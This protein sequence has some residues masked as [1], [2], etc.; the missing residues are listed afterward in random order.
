MS[1]LESIRHEWRPLLAL[2]WPLVLAEIGW[3]AMGIIDTIMVGRLPDSAVA[4]GAVSLG[5]ILFSTTSVFGGCLLLGLDTVVSQA[6]GARRMADCHRALWSALY[7]CAAL[8][9]ALMMVTAAMAAGLPRFGVNPRILPQATA[10]IRIL[11]WGTLPLMLYF[12]F[13]RYLQGI[14]LVQPVMF[15]VVSANLINL[16]GNWVLIYGH[17]GFSAMGT[18][19]SAWATGAA[20]VYMAIVL[21]SCARYY[22]RARRSGLFHVPLAP[23]WPLLSRLLKLGIPVATQVALEIGVFASATALIARLD[24]ASLAGH[25]IALNMASLTFMVPLGISSAA[26][27]RVGHLIG[28]RDPAAAGRAGW[29]ALACG[30]AFMSLAAVAF[31]TIPVRIARIYTADPAVI[32]MSVTLLAIAAV[33]QMFDGCQVVV[34]G[35]LRG[36]GNTRTPMWCNLLFYWF[37]GL[38]LGMWLCFR[39]GWGAAGLWTGLC[40]GLILIGSVLLAV[41]RHT[42]AGLRRSAAAMRPLP[43]RPAW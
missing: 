34:A 37:V 30:V 31:L 23:D 27:V 28:Q 41:W 35:A 11:N 40:C 36:T 22:D 19:G 1:A 29:S 17:L 20:R 26:A 33:F 12:G 24:A 3:M 2:A 42:V 43:A 38:P 6:Y 39:A 15:A 16:F 32:R 4:I 10:Y 9:P 18:D 25:Q 8:T 5:G 7:L 13:R 14:G 21:I